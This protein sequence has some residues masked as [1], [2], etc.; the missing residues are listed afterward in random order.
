MSCNAI[1]QLGKTTT[2]EEGVQEKDAKNIGRRNAADML[3]A[4]PAAGVK[5]DTQEV[6]EADSGLI[7]AF[8]STGVDLMF[9]L[10]VETAADSASKLPLLDTLLIWLTEVVSEHPEHYHVERYC[11]VLL[12]LA[13]EAAELGLAG[14]TAMTLRLR[15]QLLRL[16]R[17]ELADPQLRL[18]LLEWP[19]SVASYADKPTNRHHVDAL[20]R[21][22]AVAQFELDTDLDGLDRIERLLLEKTRAQNIE[23]PADQVE[24]I[25]QAGD[26]VFLA[27]Q[28]Y[29]MLSL[30]LRQFERLTKAWKN[31]AYSWRRLAGQKNLPPQ[32]MPVA[33]TLR[34][35]ERQ[36]ID[37]WQV[38]QSHQKLCREQHEHWV[39]GLSISAGEAFRDVEFAMQA[40]AN[41]RRCVFAT[42]IHGRTVRIDDE[43]I[44]VLRE[45]LIEMAWWLVRHG[46][47]QPAARI[48]PKRDLALRYTQ[49]QQDL[50]IEFL[51]EVPLLAVAAKAFPSA[52]DD[53]WNR[54]LERHLLACAGRNSVGSEQLDHY[55]EVFSSLHRGVQRL[56]GQCHMRYA[57]QQLYLQVRIPGWLTHTEGRLVPAGGDLLTVR[58]SGIE[59]LEDVSVHDVKGNK[60]QRISIGSKP[61]RVF[62]LHR[63]LGLDVNR[64]TQDLLGCKAM[65]TRA[66]GAMVAVLAGGV[67]E[68]LR[69]SVRSVGERLPKVPG[70]VGATVLM[71]GELSPI[72]DLPTTIRAYVREATQGNG[73]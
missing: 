24:F 71:G 38:A 21:H 66:S 62:W 3:A 32:A 68:V 31:R 61:Y 22:L 48:D 4:E 23:R 43:A 72:I 73:S 35:V 33:Q 29:A 8:G 28:S 16:D 26:S 51:C 67:S 54:K 10:G 42:E 46:L 9:A 49:R 39:H 45:P 25:R 63:L 30:L 52:V 57:D 18:S 5:I 59:Q 15:R 20:M 69:F 7:T 47:T 41:E 50:F 27:G 70:I 14:L 55:A 19:M 58:E 12:R 53:R 11:D 34:R 2:E 6:L 60:L 36:L 1:G 64:S 37:L 13:E 65:L 56:G 17:D 44:A 40:A